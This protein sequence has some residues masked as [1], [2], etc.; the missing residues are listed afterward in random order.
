[1][2]HIIV[3]YS[4]N[5]R[6][7]FR[8]TDLLAA[9]GSA[10]IAQRDA[11]GCQVYPLGGLRVRAIACD[12]YVI[13]DG[14]DNYGFVH[15]TIKIGAGRSDLVEGKTAESAFQVL[16]DRL[17]GG[18]EVLV[19]LSLALERVGGVKSLK[20]NEIHGHLHARETAA[21]EQVVAGS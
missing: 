21:S 5:L 3:E 20:Y 9:L 16:K 1:M 8:R 11:E 17:T 13:A 14:E 2:P 18:N 4:S 6:E 10:V 7:T 19:A 15:V 12:E